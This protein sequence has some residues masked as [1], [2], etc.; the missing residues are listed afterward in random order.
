MNTLNYKVLLIKTGF[1]V[2][3]RALGIYL[4]ITLPALGMPIMYMLSAG[5]ALSF[6]WI[7]GALFLL[8]F[9]SIQKLA[10]GIITKNVLLYTAVAIAVLVAF[11]MME[12]L[13][14]E[15]HIWQSGVFL[16][17]PAAA[18]ISGWISLAVY[19]H[20]IN[21]LSRPSETDQYESIVN[22]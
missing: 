8:L 15:D 7:A 21:N 14:V 3:L 4:L 22:A 16:L 11:Q 9:Y 19:R 10:T 18:V 6:G 12:V 17:F 1:F 2:F 5:Y 20:A 13:G